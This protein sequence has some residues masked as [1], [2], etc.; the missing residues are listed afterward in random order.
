MN[1]Q[2]VTTIALIADVAYTI[3]AKT[4]TTQCILGRDAY[5][6]LILIWTNI[7]C[8]EIFFSKTYHFYKAILVLIHIHS[9]EG[10]E[11]PHGN[12]WEGGGSCGSRSK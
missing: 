2:Q 9:L 7:Q 4:Y 10:E 11:A 5:L 1:V 3:A 8:S 6:L 12:E